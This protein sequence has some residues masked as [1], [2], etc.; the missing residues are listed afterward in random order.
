[1]R[2]IKLSA[3]RIGTVLAASALAGGG[4]ATS[5]Q[6][7][8]VGGGGGCPAVSGTPSTSVF[9][10]HVNDICGNYAVQAMVWGWSGTK[11][12][13]DAYSNGSTSTVTGFTGYTDYGFRYDT[14]SKW[15]TVCL[16]ESVCKN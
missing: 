6:A 15:I 11:Y 7:T 12:G 1:M 16:S 8:I 3:R 4:L 14:G 2:I 10:L 5:A 13:N 9:Y